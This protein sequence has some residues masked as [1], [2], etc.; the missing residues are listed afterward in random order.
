[1]VWQKHVQAKNRCSRRLRGNWQKDAKGCTYWK[2]WSLLRS[3]EGAEKELTISDS[4]RFALSISFFL[5]RALMV[6]WCSNAA[7]WW[8]NY[9]QTWTLMIPL[10]SLEGFRLEQ[11]MSNRTHHSNSFFIN[12]SGQLTISLAAKYEMRAAAAPP[13]ILSWHFCARTYARRIFWA[14]VCEWQLSAHIFCLL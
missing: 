4:F 7:T 2:D 1:M 14:S 10:P 9:C 13:W 11:S 8:N 5:G 3:L 6:Y 12:Q